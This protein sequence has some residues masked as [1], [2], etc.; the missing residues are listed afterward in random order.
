MTMISEGIRPLR[1]DD[2]GAIHSL[3]VS[4]GVFTSTEIGIALEL[5]DIVLDKPSQEDYI[6]RVYDEGDGVQGYYCLGPTPGTQGTWD[7]YWIAV[8]PA[9]QGKGIGKRLNTHAELLI[10]SEG[11]RM[12]VVET[13]SQDRYERTR[14]F[15]ATQGYDLVSRVRDYY[16]YGDDLMVYTKHLTLAEE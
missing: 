9:A 5:I 6:V 11:G 2:R 14:K 1:P 12:I 10:Q 16:S 7:L 4:T 3:L 13:S 15:Y 8:D